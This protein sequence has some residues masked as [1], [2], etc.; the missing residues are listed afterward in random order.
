MSIYDRL[1]GAR[2]DY[3]LARNSVMATA[4]LSDVLLKE[5]L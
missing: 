4:A 3:R 5:D 2:D 1:I